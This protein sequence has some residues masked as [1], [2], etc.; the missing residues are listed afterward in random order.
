MTDVPMLLSVPLVLY[1]YNSCRG[2]NVQAEC[3][4]QV[5]GVI[6]AERTEDAV[7]CRGEHCYLSLMYTEITYQPLNNC[8][9]FYTFSQFSRSKE[10]LVLITLKVSCQP[11]SKSYFYRVNSPDLIITG[12]L[13]LPKILGI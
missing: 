4:T 8:L 10:L 11:C 3:L 5:F 9:D 1:H 6:S 2:K 12:D 13:S 7:C